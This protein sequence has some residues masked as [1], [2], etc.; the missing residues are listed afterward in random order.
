MP[1]THSVFAL[2]TTRKQ[3]HFSICVQVLK[4]LVLNKG[5]QVQVVVAL[6]QD[7]S[8]DRTATLTC[9]A[10]CKCTLLSFSS[11][12]RHLPTSIRLR[13]L[14]PTQSAVQGENLD[15]LLSWQSSWQGSWQSW[16][17]GGMELENFRQASTSACPPSCLRHETAMGMT[18]MRSLFNKASP[19]VI[20]VQ[21]MEQRSL[22]GQ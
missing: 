7:I 22:R 12:P 14:T 9:S 8:M 20:N 6:F 11:P 15:Q 2:V 21:L 13:T 17:R 5:S 19:L 1:R 18:E 4:D 3:T 16:V 10:D